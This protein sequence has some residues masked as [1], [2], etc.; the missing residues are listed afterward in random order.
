VFAFCRGFHGTRGHIPFFTAELD[1]DDN[2]HN[3]RKSELHAETN[4][5]SI[6][7]SSAENNPTPICHCKG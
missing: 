2:A 1:P 4:R 3:A 5:K 7:I 6:R